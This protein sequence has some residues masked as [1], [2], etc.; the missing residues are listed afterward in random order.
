MTPEEAREKLIEALTEA[1][2]RYDA[3]AD[4]WRHSLLQTFREYSQAIGVERRLLDPLQKML[5]EVD[6]E[7]YKARR[8]NEGK[9]GTIMP[10]GR[11]LPLAIAAACVTVL[12]ERRAH[13]SVAEAE[14]FVA[15][16]TGIERKTIKGFRDNLNRGRLS[17]EVSGAYRNALATARLWPTSAMPK[18]LARLDEFVT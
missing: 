16:I 8:R 14:K 12:K 10:V 15:H 1:R 6:D 2:K 11:G 4:D 17:E 7:I 9:T 18:A 3:G 13:A 5:F